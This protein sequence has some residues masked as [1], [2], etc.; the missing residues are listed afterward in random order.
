MTASK[1]IYRTTQVYEI[2]KRIVQLNEYRFKDMDLDT[3]IDW[4]INFLG[5]DPS[6]IARW[7]LAQRI[8]AYCNEYDTGIYYT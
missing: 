8:T 4:L 7:Y 6:Y 5:I 1:M 3:V 2:F